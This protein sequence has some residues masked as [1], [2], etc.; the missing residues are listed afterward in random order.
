MAI[1]DL[2]LGGAAANNASRAMFPAPLFNAAAAPF[3]TMRASRHK[4]PATYALNRVLDFRDD[5]ALK[6]WRTNATVVAGD[7]IGILVIPQNHMLLGVHWQVHR[8]AGVALTLT[9]SLRVNGGVLPVIN[10][11]VVAAGL[12]QFGALAAITA[13]GSAAT[14]VPWYIA[15]PDIISLDL[16]AWT[17][18]GAL[19]LE[20]CA[21]IGELTAGQP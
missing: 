14:I 16:T 15:T 2:Y 1:H 10:G 21:L 20:I 5:L 9:P 7:D 11:N 8:A 6:N 3:S 18:F 17:T 19:R 13:T 12:S 4:G